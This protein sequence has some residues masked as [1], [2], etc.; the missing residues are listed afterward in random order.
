[1]LPSGY[2]V[3]ADLFQGVFVKEQA[4]ALKELG[5]AVDM[6]YVEPR[7]LRTFRLSILKA[8]HFQCSVKREDEILTIRQRGWNP[9]LNSVTGGRIWSFLTRRL[10]D[11]YIRNYGVPDIIHAHDALWAG[12]ASRTFNEEYG[13]PVVLTEHS[14][15]YTEGRVTPAKAKYARSAFHGASSVICVSRSLARDI[16]DYCDQTPTIIPNLVNSLFFCLPPKEPEESP[17]I[18][19]AIG[20]LFWVKGFD[21]LLQAFARYPGPAAKVRLRIGGD[22]PEMH[23]LQLLA[24]RLGIQDRVAFIGQL[25]RDQVREEMW[26]AHSLVVPSRFETFGIVLIEAL[27]TGLPV[28][29]TRCG[30]PEDILTPETGLLVAPESIAEMAAAMYEMTLRPRTKRNALRQVVMSRFEASVVA[31]SL[32]LHY[33]DLLKR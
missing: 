7:R 6:L 11:R 14:S 21:L 28:I 15:I 25:S 19:L 32:Y 4:V 13:I 8:S 2:S 24:A 18:F 1:M 12:Y 5:A 10:V 33:Q 3:G 29:S 27:A 31:E 30:G 22:G 23:S 20:G 16:G 9:V 26:K 17:Y